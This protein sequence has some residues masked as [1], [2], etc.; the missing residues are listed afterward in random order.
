MSE[1]CK[2]TLCECTT[3]TLPHKLGY[4]YGAACRYEIEVRSFRECE[5]T[6]KWEGSANMAPADGSEDVSVSETKGQPEAG[7]HDTH[8]PPLPLSAL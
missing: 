6:L 7:S 3:P 1:W 5:F 2:P 8:P 4:T